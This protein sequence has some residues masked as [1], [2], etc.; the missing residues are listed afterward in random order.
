MNQQEMF[1]RAY[2][3]VLGQGGL[4]RTPDGK[5]MYTT[6]DGRHCGVGHLLTAEQQ[7]AV[8]RRD[9]L[10]VDSVSGLI[11]AGILSEGF[12][13]RFAL[14]LQEAHDDAADLDEFRENMFRLAGDC[15]LTIPSET[16]VV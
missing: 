16:E 1:T 4:A 11:R 10:N 14:E 7:Q 12:N 8:L 5:C 2:L 15:D 9:W 6:P 13:R 3:G